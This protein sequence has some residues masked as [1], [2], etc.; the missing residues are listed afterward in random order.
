MYRPPPAADLRQLQPNATLVCKH[1]R[2]NHGLSVTLGFRPFPG[3]IRH[4]HKA[5]PKLAMGA[6]LGSAIRYGEY[7]ATPDLGRGGPRRFLGPGVP[8]SALALGRCLRLG[9]PLGTRRRHLWPYADPLRHGLRQFVRLWRDH[10]H[11]GADTTGA[12][13]R[14]RTTA[15]AAFW[16]GTRPVRDRYRLDRAV[17]KPRQSN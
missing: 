7:P 13:R 10:R 17:S 6:D 16:R 11:R 2:G 4:S 12:E 14:R 9:P 8:G 5:S 3:G 1:E 15:P